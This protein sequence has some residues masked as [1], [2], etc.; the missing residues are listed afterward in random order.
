MVNLVIRL[1]GTINTKPKIRET[2]RLMNLTRTNHAILLPEDPSSVG[3]L[4]IVKDYVTWGPIDAKNLADA[5][6]K[7][8]Q[9]TGGRPVTD[10]HVKA[11]SKYATI[12]EFAAAVIKGEIKYKELPEIK[13]ILRLAPPVK[14]FVSVK[15]QYGNGGDLG[16]RKDEIITLLAR[17]L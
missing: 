5:I 13:P 4:K 9:L 1:K 17:M 10:A 6:R 16:P 2:L 3:M 8:G 12:D 11:H 7:R 15:R 14:G